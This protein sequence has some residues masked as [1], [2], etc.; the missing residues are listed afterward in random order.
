MT[1]P[2]LLPKP[3]TDTQPFWDGC[4]H[5]QLRFQHCT[6]CGFVRWPPAIIC[7]NCHSMQTDWVQSKGRGKVYSFVVYHKA[8]HPAFEE[9]LPYVTAVIELAEGPRMVT[10]L[11]GVEISRIECEMEVEIVWEDITA[12]FSLPKF[13]P[14][15]TG[16]EIIKPKRR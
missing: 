2:R 16:I 11:I 13:Q 1:Y 9:R 15:T 4:R 10:N 6:D 12:E 5:H 14:I 7:P 8:Y 3:N